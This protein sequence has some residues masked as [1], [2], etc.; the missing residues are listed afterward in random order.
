MIKDRFL[1]LALAE[2][3]L[4]AFRYS[5]ELKPT[6]WPRLSKEEAAQRACLCL[7]LL[8]PDDFVEYGENLLWASRLL[9]H[10]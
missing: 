6:L 1:H 4:L 2:T 7:L 8:K 3:Q 10:S 9:F 5:T